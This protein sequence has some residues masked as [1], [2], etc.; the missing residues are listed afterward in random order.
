MTPRS[1]RGPSY[2]AM[3]VDPSQPAAARRRRPQPGQ[4]ALPAVDDAGAL[5]VD[6]VDPDD[7]GGPEVPDESL[8]AGLPSGFPA[9]SV[10]SDLSAPLSPPLDSVLSPPL[11][12]RLSVR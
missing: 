6:P 1:A 10:L 9:F 4:A 11:A 3:A 7:E 8:A 5:P 12:A 2:V